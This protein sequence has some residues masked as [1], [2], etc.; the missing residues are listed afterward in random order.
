MVKM[1]FILALALL[2][3]VSIYLSYKQGGRSNTNYD[4][5]YYIFTNYFPYDLLNIPAAVQTLINASSQYGLLWYGLIGLILTFIIFRVERGRIRQMLVWMLGISIISIFIPF[6]EQTVERS[7]RIIPL[8]TELMRGMRYLIPFF[9]IFWFYPFSMVTSNAI[10]KGIIRI[11]FVL[12]TILTI[13][14]LYINP[15]YPIIETPNVVSCWAEGKLICPSQTDYANAL[16]FIRNQTPKNAQF[17]VFLTNRWSGIEVRYLGLRPMAYAYK[18]RGQLIFTN[19]DALN[20][21]FYYQ[22]RENA[23]F[24]RNI[25]PTLELQQQRMIDFALDAEANYLL[26]DF[27]FPPDIQAKFG[28]E[29]VYQN[30]TFTIL[31]IYNMR[32]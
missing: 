11:A 30:E 17:V 6:V 22:Q 4:L 20:T 14:W 2:P 13:S 12:G 21:W 1:G 32:Q 5:V 25:S 23:I 8:Q 19:L 10:N 26:T 7:L 15:P 27:Q 18:D 9:F 31:K 24:S 29:A 16:S 3:Y 28:V